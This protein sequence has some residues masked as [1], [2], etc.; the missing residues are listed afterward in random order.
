M[1]LESVMRLVILPLLIMLAGC[2]SSKPPMEQ[3]QVAAKETQAKGNYSDKELAT[4]GGMIAQLSY[5]GAGKKA[6]DMVFTGADGRDVS[7]TD[8]TG[9]PLLVNIWATWCAPCK[10]E[11]PE[12][13][14]LAASQEGKLSVI[15]VSQD[16]EGRKPVMAFFGEASIS[17][18]EPYTDKENALLQGF[19]GNVVMPTTILYDSDGKEVWR[20]AGPVNWGDSQITGLLAQA[21]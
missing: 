8:F 13:D 6:G 4:A 19:G 18:L 14:R 2:D 1:L 15:A 16:L 10:A 20:V 11:L 17:N 9:R 12:L 21:D 5:A 3:G 7:L